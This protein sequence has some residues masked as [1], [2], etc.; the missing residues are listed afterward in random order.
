[1]RLYHHPY[2][3][4][5]RRAVMTALHLGL[6]VELVTLDLTNMQQR[7]Q[8]TKMN[9]NS[10]VPVLQDGDFLLWESCAIM[11]YLADSSPGQSIY[12]TEARARV[13]VNRWLFWASQHFAPAL[14]I[15]VWENMM[16][17]MYGVGLP[18]KR[19]LERGTLLIEQFAQVL[20][21]HL[22]GREWVCGSGVS[23]ADFAIATPL[24]YMQQAKL[25]LRQ[26]ANIQSWFGRVQ[27]LNAWKKTELQ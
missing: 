3:A 23:I 12:P 17:A 22:Q 16:K 11:Q 7:R 27:Q 6:P 18:D 21:E 15:H 20:D 26:Y 8:L 10:K 19:E 5:A 24:M 25:P 14:G 2:S 1:M 9:A 4:S 13:D